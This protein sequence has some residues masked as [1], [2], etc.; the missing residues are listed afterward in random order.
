MKLKKVKLVRPSRPKIVIGS[1]STLSL[2]P[3]FIMICNW[4][5][6]EAEQSNL[7][8]GPHFC[9]LFKGK[10]CN[11]IPLKNSEKMH[12]NVNYWNRVGFLFA[13]LSIFSIKVM[14][15]LYNQISLLRKKKQAEV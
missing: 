14:F 3:V 4:S 2:F 15:C 11:Y 7:L 1:S 12:R 6:S 10:I 13:C 9:V 8:L 5:T